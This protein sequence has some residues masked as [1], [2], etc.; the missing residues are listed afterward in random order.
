MR[1]SKIQKCTII[2]VGSFILFILVIRSISL[3]PDNLNIDDINKNKI[4]TQVNIL[5]EERK[6]CYS[7]DIRHSKEY[8]DNV[9]YFPNLNSS[10]NQ[11]KLNSAIFFIDANCS[12]SGL[13]DIT[14]R[15][16]NKR[17]K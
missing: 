12:S 2:F 4:S 7:H 1:A 9:E 11:P 13:L 14:P 10:F 8:S 6:K 3:K 16:V 17:N 15:L 5:L